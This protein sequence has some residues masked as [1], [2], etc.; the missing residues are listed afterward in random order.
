[1]PEI[2]VIAAVADAP[3]HPSDRLIGD[4]MDLPWHLPAD[5]RRFKALTSGW[6]LVMGRR[7]FESLLHQ[8]GGPLP[9][10]E[11]V[12]L[13]RHPSAVD[14]PGIHVHGSLEAAVEAFRDRDRVF[15]GGGGGV[16]GS[17]LEADAAVQADRLE[18]TLVEGTFEGD[19][20]FPPYRHL[21]GDDG[22]FALEASERHEAADGRPAFRF[23]TFVRK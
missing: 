14:H 15:I 11:N 18:L 9:N 13:T 2:V 8:F 6:P 4:G 16:Y 21:V 7:T 19:T 22:P 17:V 10:R 5:L 12:V 1:M 23:E 20:Y 3:G